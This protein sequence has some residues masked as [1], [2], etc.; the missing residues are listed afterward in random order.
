MRVGLVTHESSLLHDTGYGHPERPSRVEAA[1]R[2]V[3]GSGL[4]IVERRADRADRDL[5]Q[6]V[7]RREY[8]NGIQDFCAGGGGAIDPDTI[9]CEDSWDAALDAAGG[10]VTAASMVESGECDAGF[11]AMRPPGHHALVDRAMGF[12]LFNN[13]AILTRWLQERG[14]RVAIV[15]WDVHHGNGTQDIFYD[16]PDVLYVSFHESPQYPGT[17]KIGESGR[18]DATGTVINFPWPHGTRG[19]AY[20]WAIGNVVGP[21]LEQFGPDWV[22]VSAGYDAHRA[23]PLAGIALVEDDYA[24]MAMRL[25]A[26]A[27]EARWTVVLEGGYDL[28]AIRG[29]AEATVRGIAGT[30][31]FAPGP[32]SDELGDSAAMVGEAARR[33]AG[34]YWDLD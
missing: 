1:A 28:D 8:V 16:D 34:R 19:P 24:A 5:I 32:P 30:H 3:R 14:N 13:V 29:S 25:R 33:E 27:P 7:H 20:H 9:A 22:I 31:V 18:G 21:V 23:D 12:C 11:V 2:G 15:D 17:G 6:L 10:T 4:E 26:S